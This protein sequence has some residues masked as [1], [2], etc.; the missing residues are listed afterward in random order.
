MLSTVYVIRYSNPTGVHAAVERPGG[1]FL[2][3]MCDYQSLEHHQ[4]IE[5]IDDLTAESALAVNCRACQSLLAAHF[6]RPHG[7]PT[8]G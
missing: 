3:P 8:T 5:E 1:G 2:S 7:V 6:S 4:F